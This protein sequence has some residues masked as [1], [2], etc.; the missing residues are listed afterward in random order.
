MRGIDQ[1][2]VPYHVPGWPDGTLEE[3]RFFSSATSR[4]YSLL[5]TS[6]APTMLISGIQMHRTT[7]I[8]PIADTELKVRAIAPVRGAVLDTANGLGYTAIEAART[9]EHVVTVRVYDRFD[10]MATSKT[11]VRAK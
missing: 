9:A 1:H 7:G 10:N 6:G 3:I 5:A 2:V 8:D 4:E 11:V